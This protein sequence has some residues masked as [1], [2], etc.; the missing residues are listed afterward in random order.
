MKRERQ[1]L[2]KGQ[3]TRKKHN[4]K[5]FS[6]QLHKKSQT[7]KLKK[8]E[9]ADLRERL[10]SYMEYH[11]LPTDMKA[12]EVATTKKA[13]R[14]AVLT[15]AFSY[16]TIPYQA[17]FK[18]GSVAA[19]F[20]VLVVPFMAERTVPGD[21]LYAVK[22]QFNEEVRGTLTWGSYEKVEWE[23][24]RLNRRIAEARL[25]ADEGLLTKEVEAEVAAAVRVHSDNAKREIEV[26]RASDADDAA[27]ATITFDSSLEVQA[28]A[29]NEIEGDGTAT[30]AGDLISEAIDESLVKNP[31][32]EVDVVP[33]YGKLM[34][35]VEMNTTRVRELL[36]SL[37]GAVTVQGLVDVTRRIDDIDRAILAAILLSQA[38]ETE[39]AARIALVDV[40]TR[41][42]KLIVFM[43]DLEVREHVAIESVVPVVLTLNEMQADRVK[44]TVELSESIVRITAAIQSGDDADLVAKLVEANE[45]LEIAQALLLEIEDYV[46]FVAQSNQTLALATDALL[47]IAQEGIEMT[48][49]MMEPASTTDDV[50]EVEIDENASSTVE[51]VTPEPE[52]ATTTATS[53]PEAQPATTTQSEIDTQ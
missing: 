32:A 4:M 30:E 12:V 29:F 19:V 35:R 22:V 18:F 39:L 48:Q 21:T 40:L 25:L 53:T 46:T 3:L 20:M 38:P 13:P 31:E 16:F 28:Q 14:A 23:T 34:A 37:D 24:T 17:L 15:E 47:L 7:V 6:E 5:R 43:S 10:V 41:T 52:N 49:E 1:P 45:N 2:E 36:N 50:V 9:Q 33:A 51:T 8:S 11:P 44:R 42:Q 26:L 27:I